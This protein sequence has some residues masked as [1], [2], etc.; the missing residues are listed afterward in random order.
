MSRRTR[1]QRICRQLGL[2]PSS[3]LPGRR[4]LV[5]LQVDSLSYYALQASLGWRFLPFLTRLIRG[6]HRLHAYQTGL[7]ATTPAFQLG[8]FY[9]RSEHV[10][11]FRWL[12]K[13]SG[14]VMNVKRPED[15]A[16]AERVAAEHAPGLLAQGGSAHCAIVSGGAERTSLVLSKLGEP[17]PPRPR[18]RRRVGMK[19]ALALRSTWRGL[20]LL[21][22]SVWEVVLELGEAVRAEYDG[23]LTRGE[24]P[25]LLVRVLT[26]VVFREI[27]AQNV[28]WDLARGAPVIY[29]NFAGYDELAHH[30]G[31]MSLSARL[32]LR[33]TD[34]RIREI[35]RAASRCAG[36]EYD[37]YVFSDHGQV[38]TIPFQ[39]LTGRTLSDEL[40]RY[41]L[42]TREL[43]AGFTEAEITRLRSLVGLQRELEQ[44]LPQ[45]LAWVARRL[46]DYIE[47]Q[48]PAEPE[49]RG[50]RQFSE[51]T[52]LPTS[53]LC[54]LYLTSLPEPLSL[55]QLRALRPEL[56]RALVN[57][58]AIWA[59]VG[60][61]WEEGGQQIAE[62]ASASGAAFL[63]PD[64]TRKVIGLDPLL[65]ADFP[66]GTAAAL[67]RLAF[68]PNSGDA[69]LFGAKIHG[70]AV[71]F[72]EEFGGH[73]G[74]YREE[75]VAFMLAPPQVSFDFSQ[76]RHHTELYRFFY[77]RYLATPTDAAT[78]ERAHALQ[79]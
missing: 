37:V 68:S 21:G 79:V 13:R 8:L 24:W 30:R 51:I 62:V 7:P 71:N 47:R 77:D 70:K 29:A 54:H 78:P 63:W 40:A 72:Q 75:Q 48:L 60:R 15:A 3:A 4:G 14:R 2:E 12:Q 33:G 49:L 42:E 17:S 16:E 59:L 76:I 1:A 53:D 23:R 66:E 43:P 35:Y 74:P 10:V 56:W 38:P 11:G 73:G 18:P 6:G 19:L 27:A 36:R 22:A 39:L 58:P 9:G 44:V 34:A 20:R 45:K 5:L 55:A 28:V 50:Y 25:F 52:V 41:L 65:A 32:A 57:H 31:P 67:H 64:G 61:G 69:I 26:N 46:G